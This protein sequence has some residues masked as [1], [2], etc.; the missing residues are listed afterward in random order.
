MTRR[1]IRSG[2]H[3]NPR[4]HKTLPIPEGYRYYEAGKLGHIPA[5]VREQ[6]Q[7]IIK[8]HPKTKFI[9]APKA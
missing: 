1:A 8:N 3:V 9:I 4:T 7:T 2:A 6:A 5:D